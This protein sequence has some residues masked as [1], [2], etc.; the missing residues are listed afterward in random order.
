MKIVI[1][2]YNS[3]NV[4]SV[5]N[6]L[7]RL[8]WSY[9]ISDNE[10]EI[11]AADKVILPGVGSASSTMPFLTNKGLDQTIKKVQQPLLGIC[12]GMQLLCSHTE[13]GNT[14]ALGIFNVSVKKFPFK[15]GY[16]IPHMGWNSIQLS[17]GSWLPS[18]V[19]N[20]SVYFV[21][22]YYVESNQ[23]N[24]A[25][26]DYI[27]PFSVAMKKDNFYATQFHP[28]K[29]GDIGELILKEFLSL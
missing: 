13:E 25:T 11:L 18:S 23:W 28:E 12:L 29:S 19:Q 1:I 2:K 21:H 27:Q 10:T 14:D 8:G 6:A 22:S 24:A 4:K 17:E 20:K 9:S 5:A 26:S 16:K 3:G 15:Q 7:E